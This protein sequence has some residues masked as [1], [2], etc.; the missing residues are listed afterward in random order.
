MPG[1]PLP[2]SSSVKG[3]KSPGPENGGPSGAEGFGPHTGMGDHGLTGMPPGGP[4]GPGGP[5]GEDPNGDAKQSL[6]QQKKSDKEQEALSMA[7]NL[8]KK[9]HDTCMAII[10]NLR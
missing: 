1:K 4:G 3:S 5:Q 8:Q 7:S 2:T 9:A 6:D 10:A